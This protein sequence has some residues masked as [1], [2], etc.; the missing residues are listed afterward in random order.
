MQGDQKQKR[1]GCDCVICTRCR[2]TAKKI[3]GSCYCDECRTKSWKTNCTKKLMTEGVLYCLDF[4]SLACA[5]ALR[6]RRPEG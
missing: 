3:K 6:S 4:W 2:K 5:E 1:K